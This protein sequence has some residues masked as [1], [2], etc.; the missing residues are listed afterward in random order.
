MVVTVQLSDMGL[1]LPPV[2]RNSQPPQTINA[3][4]RGR[5]DAPDP[6]TD[7]SLL[8]P[9]SLV[10]L[11]RS[12]TGRQHRRALRPAFDGRA[13]RVNGQPGAGGASVDLWAQDHEGWLTMQAKAS[14]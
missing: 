11:A 5:P 13:L 12:Q 6:A 8:L 3:E 14:S 2:L 7:I 4:H 10:Q 9:D 1:Y